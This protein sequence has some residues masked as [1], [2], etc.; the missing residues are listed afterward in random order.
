MYDP[1]TK[2]VVTIDTCF[3]THHLNLDDKGIL[4]FTCQGANMVGRLDSNL[5]SSSH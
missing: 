2:E 4:W 3:G 1:K 5:G